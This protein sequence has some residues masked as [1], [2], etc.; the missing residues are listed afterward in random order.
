[1][2][3]PA[4]LPPS[5]VPAGSRAADPRTPEQIEADLAAARVRIGRTLEVLQRKVAPATLARDAADAVKRALLQ[6]GMGLGLVA[7]ALAQGKRSRDGCDESG[8]VGDSRETRDSRPAKVLDVLADAAVSAVA[9]AIKETLT[10][11]PPEPPPPP[12][13]TRPR[14]RRRSRNGKS[15]Q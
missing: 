10:P 5:R 12:T 11:S 14:R 4:Y 2:P 6:R 1:M 3:R 8:D 15:E 9:A 7:R 13:A